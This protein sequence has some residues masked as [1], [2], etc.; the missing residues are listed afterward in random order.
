MKFPE[1][2][3]ESNLIFIGKVSGMDAA[4]GVWSGIFQ[5]TQRV[6]YDVL[7]VLVGDNSAG[8]VDIHHLVVDQTRSASTDPAVIGLSEKLFRTGNIL[9]VFAQTSPDPMDPAL[10]RLEGIEPDIDVLRLDLR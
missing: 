3:A 5:V 2:I 6:S 10:K 7:G 1:L 4:S 8:S 9:L